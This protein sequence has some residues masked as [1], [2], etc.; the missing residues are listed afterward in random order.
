MNERQPTEVRKHQIARAAQE[1]IA[2]DGLAKFTTAAIA[3]TVGISEGAL[4][5][6]VK[7]KEEII[8]LVIDE[9]EE[10]LFDGFPPQDPD[11]L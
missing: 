7:N 10:T 9:I 6:H 11:P 1:L 4:F 8:K 2:R 5:R 3:R